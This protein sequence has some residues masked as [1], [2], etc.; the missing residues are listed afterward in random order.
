MMGEALQL[1][2]ESGKAVPKPISSGS[3]MPGWAIL[4]RALDVA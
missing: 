3:A 1:Q 2:Q 4:F